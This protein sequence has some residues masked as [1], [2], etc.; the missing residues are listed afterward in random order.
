MSFCWH[1]GGLVLIG[2]GIGGGR[3][4]LCGLS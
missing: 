3:E 2:D 4:L 1:G